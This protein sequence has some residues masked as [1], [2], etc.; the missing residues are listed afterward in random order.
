MLPSLLTFLAPINDQ[1]S[2][3]IN[4]VNKPHSPDSPA[5]S[6]VAVGTNVKMLRI[7]QEKWNKFSFPFKRTGFN[8]FY[9]LKSG[10][11]SDLIPFVKTCKQEGIIPFVLGSGRS[12][13]KYLFDAYQ[14]LEKPFNL[15]YLTRAIGG[16]EG[17]TGKLLSVREPF[18]CHLSLLGIQS[19]YVDMRVVNLIEKEYFNYLRLGT[20]KKEIAQAEPAIRFSDLVLFDINSLGNAPVPAKCHPSPIGFSAEEACQLVYYGGRSERNPL[21]CLFGWPRTT[22]NPNLCT[23]LANL[24]W[25]FCFGIEY[26]PDVYPPDS[27]ELTSYI[28]DASVSENQLNFFKHKVENKWW[29]KYP[30]KLSGPLKEHPFIPC[31][32][33]DYDSVIKGESLSLHLLN[34]LQCYERFTSRQ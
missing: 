3:T 29:L 22:S 34:V 16:D 13:A 24:I 21:F 1:Q 30:N 19:P 8:G 2:P 18:L 25:Y 14:F 33:A 11:A 20:L 26:R 27:R 4:I 7:V 12:P 6:V 15:A 23:L 10:K 32:Y 5:R 17:L 31:D 9:K 28:L